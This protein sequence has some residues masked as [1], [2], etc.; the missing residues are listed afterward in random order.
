MARPILTLT[1]DFGL[2]DHYV[3][4]MK[5]VILSICPLAQIVDISHEVG[6]FAILEGAYTIAQAYGEFPRKTVHVVVVDPGVGSARRPILME[7]AGQYFIGPDN[8]VLGMILA[9]EKHKVRLIAKPQYLRH[10][11]SQTFHGRD[12]FSPVAAHL[13][14]GV[15]A[16]RIGPLIKDYLRPAFVGAQRTGK[17]TW[18]GQILKIDRFGNVITSFHVDD[19]PG[20]GQSSF[21]LTAGAYELSV[22]VRHYAEAASGDLVVMVGSGGYLEVAMNQGSAAERVAS[23]VGAA[24]ELKLW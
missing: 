12:I 20:I 3:A 5:G 11:V 1:T 19:F 10:P 23:D 17:H 9:R 22:M 15:P 2:S 8:G 24:V 21:T 16:S 14:G 6:A 4:A 7:A 13:A 18:V